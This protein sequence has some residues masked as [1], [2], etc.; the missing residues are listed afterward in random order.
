MSLNNLLEKKPWIGWAV[1]LGSLTAVFLLGLLAASIMERRSEALIA[2]APKVQIKSLDP[3]NSKWGENYPR[4]YNSFLLTQEGN[5]KSKY[6]GN[7]V[8]DMLEQAPAMVIL[9]GGYGFS[10]DYNQPRGHFYAV[11]DIRKTLRTGA[12]KSENEG[13]QPNTCWTCKSPDV[14]HLMKQMGI[15]NFYQGKWASAG[16]SIK[17][18]IGCSDCHDP[19]NLNLT[20]TRP[21]LVEAFARQGV[22]INKATHQEKRSLVCAQCHVEYYFKGSDPKKPGTNLTFP[23]D[24]GTTVDNIEKYYDALEFSD[25]THSLS[26]APM[27]K[28]QHP[29]Y[30]MWKMGIHAKRGVSCADCHM[31]YVAEGGIKYTSHHIQSPLNNI[32]QSCQVCHRESEE[33]LKNNVYDNQTKVTE[34]RERVEQA[35][36]RTHVEAKIAWEKGASE[37]EMQPILKLIRQS[38]WRWDFAAAGHG[39]SAHAPLESVR[40]LGH[41]L[42]KAGEA[43]LLLANVLNKHGVAWPIDMP[44]LSTKEKAMAYVGIDLPKLKGEKEEF[45]KSILPTWDQKYNEFEKS[46][47]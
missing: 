18:P 34:I 20:I 29:D 46:L 35:L 40:M 26:K 12:P 7:G 36:V 47:D 44:D 24:Q 13:P 11:E 22:D 15:E 3:R 2:F 10:K 42:E 6:N 33:V 27:L 1:F 45:I 16:P 43:R 4:E 14:L 30:E 41:A 28:A 9:W 8:V 23:W 38:Q 31:P 19:K 21:A 5:F 25:W 37:E 17:N 32:N 39:N